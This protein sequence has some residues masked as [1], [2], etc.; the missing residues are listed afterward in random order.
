[1]GRF[2]ARALPALV[3]LVVVAIGLGVGF[4]TGGSPV[5]ARSA[6]F[7]IESPQASS[8]IG[9][10]AFVEPPT[11]PPELRV[12]DAEVP[13]LRLFSSPGVPFERMPVV[14]DAT[15][16][17]NPVVLRV[18]STVGT[19]LQVRLG[20]SGTAAPIVYVDRDEMTVRPA[21]TSVLIELGLARIT[22][23]DGAEIR[24]SEPVSVGAEATPTPAGEFYVDA[25]ATL[26]PGDPA[27]AARLVLGRFSSL[28][29][30]SGTAWPAV[31]EGAARAEQ[32]GRPATDGRILLSDDAVSALL[33]LA[34]P[35]TPVQIVS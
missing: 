3:G 19:M 4:G 2:V 1:M 24:L 8:V 13:E 30:G 25:V 28:I 26:G 11:P 10:W 20:P 32:L 16:A 15:N 31:L 35:G 12:G 21:S 33:A 29:G 6:S 34:P 18:L 22:V 17:R 23:F 14:A 7:R 5:V 9:S 27:G